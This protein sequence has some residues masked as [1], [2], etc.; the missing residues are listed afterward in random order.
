[1]DIT[2]LTA[3]EVFI[4]SVAKYRHVL[5]VPTLGA[6]IRLAPNGQ[7]GDTVV[8]LPDTLFSL[9]SALL[10]LETAATI[11]VTFGTGAASGVTQG[12]LDAEAAAR[13]LVDTSTIH[14][15][16]SGEF[17]AIAL[18]AAPVGADILLVEDSAAANAK[19]RIT[20]GTLPSGAPSGPAG[21]D[22]SGTYP[23]PTVIASSETVAG[24]VELATQAETNTG[25]D[26][27]RAVTPLKLKTTSLAGRDSTAIHSTVAGEI[28]AVTLK[29][30]P[31]AADILLIED[32][33]AANAKKKVALSALPVAAHAATHAAAGA[34]PVAGAGLAVAIAPPTNFTPGSATLAGML[35]GIDTAL[36]L[37]RLHQR[38]IAGADTVVIGDLGKILL[39]SGTFTLSYTAAATLGSGFWFIAKNTSTG[40]ITHDPSGA[41]TLDSFTTVS[42]QA[43]VERIIFCTGAVFLSLAL[44]QQLVD[45]R[46]FTAGGTWTKHPWAR[47]V[48]IDL[49]GAGGGGGG[50]RG[51]AAASTRQAGGGGGGGARHHVRML[52]AD[53]AA[54]EAVTIGAGGAGGAGGSSADGTVGSAGGTTSFGSHLSAFGGGGGVN[55]STATA[56]SGGGGGGQLSAGTVGTAGASSGGTP[57][58]GTA[59]EGGTE[60]GAGCLA[61]FGG[62]NAGNGGGAG[63]GVPS[64][65]GASGGGGASLR[66]GAGGGAGGVVEADNTQHAG[67]VGGVAGVSGGAGGAGGAI[68]GGAGSAGTV[69]NNNR[70]G[71]GGGGGGGNSGGTGGAGGA[72]AIPGGGGGGGG[73]GTTIGGAGTSGARGEC[74][75]RSFG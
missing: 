47:E 5:G 75:I 22:L 17:A 8:N 51:G 67:V 48:D 26:D 1:M 55:G 52:A 6:G 24:K 38:S 62:K 14:K 42:Q 33:A 41:E 36:A 70:S 74:R 49:V 69:G 35:T 3:V 31:V 28:A 58:T 2:N 59:G 11:S 40:V 4:G 19:K 15:A 71:S 68:A 32:S 39:L 44:Q 65:V 20:I 30:T 13:G 27:V 10:A 63:G 29:A 16:I 60:G 12:E 37:N 7:P 64:L 73:G 18:K 54:T 66:G 57:N 53:F 21:G 50:A 34:D 46:L 9:D 56:R 61:A 23:N 25:T 45:T 72:G 43:G